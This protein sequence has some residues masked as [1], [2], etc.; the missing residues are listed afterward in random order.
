MEVKEKE[1]VEVEHMRLRSHVG[2][3][4]CLNTLID[5]VKAKE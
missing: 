4:T 5:I 3:S 1:R 2:W